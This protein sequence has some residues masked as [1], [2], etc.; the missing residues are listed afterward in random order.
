MIQ[1]LDMNSRKENWICI[2]NNLSNLLD[3]IYSL[4]KMLRKYNHKTYNI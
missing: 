3:T 4:Q 1:V 2:N